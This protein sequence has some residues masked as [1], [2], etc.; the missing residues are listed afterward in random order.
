MPLS[1]KLEHLLRLAPIAEAEK[2]LW[3]EKIPQMDEGQKSLLILNL[4]KEIIVQFQDDFMN[5]VEGRIAE[6]N[7]EGGREYKPEDFKNLRSKMLTELMERV[8]RGEELL[9]QQEIAARL[10]SNLS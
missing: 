6:M 4:W 5:A 10:K 8:I 9:K 1:L 2:E 3:R 7:K